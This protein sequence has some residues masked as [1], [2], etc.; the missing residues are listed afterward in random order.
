MEWINFHVK[1]GASH[2]FI[3]DNESSDNLY[4]V[5][6]DFITRGL[7]TYNTISGKRRQTDAYNHAIY[8]YRQNLNISQ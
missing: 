4:E 1:Q 3:Y 2:F 8:N 6:Q 7:V 5:L